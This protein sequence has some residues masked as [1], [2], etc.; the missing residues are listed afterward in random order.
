MKSLWATPHRVI[1]RQGKVLLRHFPSQ[2]TGALPVLMVFALVNRPYILDLYPGRSVIESLNHGGLDIYLIDWGVPDRSDRFNTLEDYVYGVIP[3]CAALVRRRSGHSTIS[4]L[5]YCMGGTLALMYA[6]LMPQGL[7]KLA[8]MAAPVDF[9]VSESLLGL[10]SSP[11]ILPVNEVARA[12]GNIP[13]WMLEWGFQWMRPLHNMFDKYVQRHQNK[14]DREFVAFFKAMERW[15][16][17]GVN[18]PGAVFEEFVRECYQ[19]NNL[20]KSRL[21]LADERVHLNHIQCP[22]LNLMAAED[23]LVPPASSRSLEKILNKQ[24]TNWEFPVG[25]IGLAVSAMAHRRVWPKVA[26]WFRAA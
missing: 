23:H 19:K 2:R 20:I 8:L 1:W 13:A 5:G 10:W 7:K 22:V 11:Q 25:H 6:S 3:D 17:D 9:H 14:S 26:R 24:V 4:M 21:S 16:H 12:F 18:I 15:I